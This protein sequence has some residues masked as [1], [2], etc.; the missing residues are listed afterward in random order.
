MMSRT[1]Q[2]G[3]VSSR[4]CGPAKR[5]GKDPLNDRPWQREFSRLLEAFFG[6]GRSFLLAKGRVALYAGLR[7]MDLPPG[8]KV[9]LPG[10]TCMAVPS[11]V[12]YAGL[13]PAYVDIDPAT[14]NL[15]PLL[16]ERTS[17]EGVSALIV[18]HTYGI[19]CAMGRILAWAKTHGIS[20]IE[21]CCHTFGTRSEG[22]LCGTFGAFAFMSGQWNKPFSTGL[23]GVLFVNDPSLADRASRLIQAEALVPGFFRNLLL[24]FQIL[25]YGIVVTPR[26]SGRITR[27]YRF[28]SRLGLVVGSSTESEL[29]GRMPKDYFGAMAQCQAR[30]GS[31]ELARIEQN[32][33]HRERLTAYYG[34]R[35][36]ELGFEPCRLNHAETLP[37]L[38]YPVRV[39]NKDEVLKRAEREGVEIGSWFEVPLH[40][41]GTR[42]ED[43][44][45][46]PGTCPEGESAARQVVNL[47]THGKVTQRTAERTLRFLGEFAKPVSQRQG[48]SLS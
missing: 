41:A 8:S 29:K 18:Q 46:Q 19:P 26:T 35:L 5:R 38:R 32:L 7:A 28:L 3:L 31:R 15:D 30:K 9:L 42:M 39:G 1:A 45:Y 25:A 37:L 10:Y 47:P 17:P 12:Q 14:Y 21:D 6:T 23:G 40:P 16:L 11:A 48:R 13:A 20:V 24:A 22:R 33:G 43:F 27:L 2:Q 44:G 4:A 36:P 34:R